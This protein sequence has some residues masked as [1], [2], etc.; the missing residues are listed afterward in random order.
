MVSIP[1]LKLCADSIS[2]P[3]EK[4]FKT[5]LWNGRFQ[6]ECKKANVIPIHK[7]DDEQTIRNNRPVSLLSNWGKLFDCLLY[8]TM[9][10]FF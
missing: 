5:C 9:F 1:M 2:K 6:L 3:L 7:K 4:I 10:I 8:D